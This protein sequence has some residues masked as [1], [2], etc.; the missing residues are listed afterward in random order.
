M[1]FFH[2]LIVYERLVWFFAYVSLSGKMRSLTALLKL[3]EIKY[4]KRSLLS[5]K[6]FAGISPCCVT[7][8]VS[9]LCMILLMN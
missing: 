7:F 5:F 4:E 9:K 1:I 2:F 8:D 6:I 3:S